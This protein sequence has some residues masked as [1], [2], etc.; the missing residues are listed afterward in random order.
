METNSRMV[1]S[2]SATNLSLGPKRTWAKTRQSRSN[3]RRAKIDMNNTQVSPGRSD[4]ELRGAVHSAVGRMD[5]WLGR[6]GETSQDL[7]DFYATKYGQFAKRIYYRRPLAGTL[8]VAPFV[9]M[10][11]FVP[12][13]RGWFWPKTRFPLADA[14][15]AMG[16]A[17]LHQATGK[18]DY[19]SRAKQFLD[20][21]ERSRCPGFKHHGWGYPF[22]WETNGGNMRS[23]TPLITTVPYC[24]EAFAAV[25]EVEGDNRY[26]PTL[27]SIAQHMYEDYAQNQIDESVS[28]TSYGP[29]DNSRIVNANAY[30]AYALT[31]AAKDFQN[32]Q[33]WQSGERNL[34][35]VLRSQQ[36]DGS[37]LYSTDGRN[38]FTD[39]FH[40][41]FVMKA[42]AKIERLTGHPGCH[43][44]LERGVRYYFDHLVDKNDLPLPLIG[45]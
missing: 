2:E 34:N 39:H 45:S 27:H 8:C 9:F 12:A 26:R 25:N 17:Y 1:N 38:S 15:Y 24:Y 4:P 5:D 43:D 30:R 22:D 10:E 37:W 42:L 36:D 44:A 3:A 35:F 21:L 18:K 29:K 33:Y 32:E 28:S 31:R 7:Y 13:M 23:A 6:F 19:L 11:A 40:T 16:F 14:H 20:A 41:C